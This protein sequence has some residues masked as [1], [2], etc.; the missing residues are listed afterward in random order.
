MNDLEMRPG[1]A[2]MPKR[3]RKLDLNVTGIPMLYSALYVF[4][5]FTSISAFHKWGSLR[6]WILSP[7]AGVDEYSLK[8]QIAAPAKFQARSKSL[9]E[10]YLLKSASFECSPS[11]ESLTFYST[12]AQVESPSFAG[13]L[14]PR[15]VFARLNLARLTDGTETFPAVYIKRLFGSV[16]C[17]VANR[18][19]RWS[20][21]NRRCSFNVTFADVPD[22]SGL[23]R[24]KMNEIC[25][26][27]P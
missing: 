14:V 21:I 19:W 22:K 24:L 5:L 13:L 8:K 16:T 25:F 27:L 26:F 3:K 9:V 20:G 11:S 7:L 6:R 18:F 10:D 4:A 1:L 23:A 15:T 17:C 12:L 2:S